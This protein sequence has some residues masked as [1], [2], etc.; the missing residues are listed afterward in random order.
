MPLSRTLGEV[1]RGVWADAGPASAI[2]SR[3][4][5]VATAMRSM[6]VSFL[7]GQDLGLSRPNEQ[8]NRRA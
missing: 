7:L 8:V 6:V 2:P 3:T 5:A 4:M 1:G